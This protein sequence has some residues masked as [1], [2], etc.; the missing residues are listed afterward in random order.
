VTAFTRIGSSLWDWEPWTTLPGSDARLLWLALF[1]SGEAKRHVPGLWQGGIPMMADAAR[2]APDQVLGALD[3]LLDRELVEYDPK[4]RV[5]RLCTLPDAG[6]YPSNGRVIRG[7]WT[8]F[9]TVPECG[10]RDAH[11]NTLRWI[12]THGALVSGKLVTA[13]HQSTWDETFGRIAI[14]TPRRR[15]VRRLAD[16]DTSTHAQASL[17]TPSRIALP[18]VRDQRSSGELG[19]PQEGVDSVDNSAVLR[20]LNENKGPETV[21]ETVS[22]TVSYTHRIPDPGSRIPD[23]S[24]LSGSGEGGWGGGHESGKPRFTLVPP[25]SATQ[26][27]N[28]L[29]QGPWDKSLDSGCQE[30]V[31]AMIPGWASS[32][33]T[34]AD[35]RVLAEYNAHTNRR[36]NARFLLG[37]DILAEIATAKKVLDWRDE[38]AAAMLRT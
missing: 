31:G 36:W 3:N 16:S 25:Y 24:F 2:M 14:P 9:K 19:Y 26:V 6:E 8:K 7:W 27:L 11:V 13:D 34:G 12:M 30:A 17:F 4:F 22:D 18:P 5:L 21:Y 35:F 1:T 28:E 20:Q 10:V 37:C 38:R 29:A 32:G 15:G 33:V 23:P